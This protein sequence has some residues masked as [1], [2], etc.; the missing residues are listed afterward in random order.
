MK[1]DTAKYMAISIELEHKNKALKKIVN[2]YK[3]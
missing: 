1:Q 2:W 3:N